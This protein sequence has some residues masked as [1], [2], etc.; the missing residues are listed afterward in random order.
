MPAGLLLCLRHV[1]YSKFHNL[2]SRT[3]NLEVEDFL[4]R[5]FSYLQVVFRS[6]RGLK[7][8]RALKWTKHKTVQISRILASTMSSRFERVSR[9]EFDPNELH[10]YAKNIG[11]LNMLCLGILEK[12]ARV[13]FRFSNV[14]NLQH[15]QEHFNIVSNN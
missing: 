5:C 3:L 15:I 11:T 14:E 1:R 12:F 10:A 2:S 8:A 13:S 9:V 4:E 7:A 6:R